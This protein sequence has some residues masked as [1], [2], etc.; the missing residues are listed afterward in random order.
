MVR[1]LYQS[2]FFGPVF[3]LEKNFNVKILKSGTESKFGSFLTEHMIVEI[4]V[5]MTLQSFK[6]K[7]LIS[8]GYPD[9]I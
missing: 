5:W 9:K 2:K 3:L 1:F 6:P 7:L 8:E 4:V